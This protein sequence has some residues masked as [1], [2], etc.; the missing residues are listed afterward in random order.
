[1]SAAAALF[2]VVD[3]TLA[4]GLQIAQAI[5]AKDEFTRA[6]PALE[7]AWAATSNTLAVLAA[8]GEAELHALVAH[9]DIV[10]VPRSVFEEP[11]LDGRLTAVALAPGA[12]AARL[13]RGLPPALS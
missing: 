6:H 4:P 2:V 3:G 11:D 10:D 1:M 9:A 7:A 13:V 8:A 5:H 12:A